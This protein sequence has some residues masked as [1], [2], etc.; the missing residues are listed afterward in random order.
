MKILRRICQVLFSLTLLSLA[1]G[2]VGAWQAWVWW[3]QEIL[4]PELRQSDWSGQNLEFEIPPGTAAQK[5]GED[6]EAAEIIRSA[7]AWRLWTLWQDLTKREGGYQAG[8]YQ[9]S[10][11]ETLPTIA[12]KV[13]QGKVVQMSFTIPEGWS[14]RQMAA[15]FESRGYFSAQE[16]ITAA[17]QIPNAKYPWLPNNLAHLEGFLYP[18]TYLLPK[19][20]VTPQA[21]IEIMLTQ[22]EKVALPLYQEGKKQTNFT[23]FEWVILGSIVEKEAVVGKE[24]GVIAGVF[25]NRLRRGMRLQ[26]DPTVEYG[27][28][29][30][31]TPDRPLTIA[32]VNTPSAYNTY[33]NSGLPPTPIASPGLAS[34]KAALYP[35]KT[36]YIYF[37]ARYDGTHVFSKTLREHN[38]AMRIIRQQRQRQR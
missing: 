33:L 29:I 4:P 35:A 8:I 15:Y 2:V 36:D 38:R 7:K 12:E 24:R 19:G 32:Q 9:F 26:T 27:L 11:T 20:G 21:I 28:G 22:F 37:V 14:I 25:V 6:L 34:L 31:Q 13:W 30:K 16:F 23:L 1:A 5:I 10:P 18:D 17:S 3:Q